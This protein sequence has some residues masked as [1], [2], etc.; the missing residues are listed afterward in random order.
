MFK[1]YDIRLYGTFLSEE[2]QRGVSQCMM[3][4]H[5]PPWLVQLSMAAFFSF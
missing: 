1:S 4:N 2:E 3:G 5:D